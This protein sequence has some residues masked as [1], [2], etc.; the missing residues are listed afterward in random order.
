[1]TKMNLNAVRGRDDWYLGL[2]M[3]GED[4]WT[5]PVYRHADHAK[6]EFTMPPPFSF[7]AVHTEAVEQI[8]AWE[9]QEGTGIPIM[10][11]SYRGKH[12]HALKPAYEGWHSVCDTGPNNVA[13]EQ[14][15][16]GTR[17]D[18]TCP[19]CLKRLK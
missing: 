1:M 5:V 10:H 18:V 6:I 12:T 9:T 3:R 14:I 7:A 15:F 16:R 19:Q 11:P 13:A 2:I 4:K 17:D 8:V